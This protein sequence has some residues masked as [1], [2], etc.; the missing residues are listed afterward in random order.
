MLSNC[1]RSSSR[2]RLRSFLAH[3]SESPCC[4]FALTATPSLR[5]GMTAVAATLG[6]FGGFLIAYQN[7]SGMTLLR[8]TPPIFPRTRH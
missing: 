7:S 1:A 3:L 5:G 4:V 2:P 8:P 6:I